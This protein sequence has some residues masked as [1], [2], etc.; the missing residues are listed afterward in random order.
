MAQHHIDERTLPAA[1]IALENAVASLIDPRPTS[2]AGRVVWIDSIY[3]E[4]CDAIRSNSGSSRSVPGP[5]TPCWLDGVALAA[6]INTQARKW[7]RRG[8]GPEAPTVNR[9]RYLLIHRYRPQDTAMVDDIAHQIGDW[10]HRYRVLV[11]DKPKS[12]PNPCPRCGQKWAYRWMDGEKVRQ[13]ALQV[14]I[15]VCRCTAC[16]AEWQPSQYAFLARVL[17]YAQPEGVIA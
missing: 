12:L 9:L 16:H 13:A 1:R 15:E 7:V 11:D 5:Q 8:N 10:V 3:T 4:L 6:E 14:T 17:G 2:T